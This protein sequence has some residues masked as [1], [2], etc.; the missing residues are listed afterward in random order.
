M[1]SR[2]HVRGYRKYESLTFT[3]HSKFNIL[4]GDNEAGKSTLLEA[5]TLALTGRINGRPAAEEISPFWFN[6]DIVRQFFESR[7]NGQSAALPEILIE[8]T[9]EDRD[10]F[11]KLI[12][13]NNTYSPAKALSGVTFRVRPDSDYGEELEQYL[14]DGATRVLPVE[15]YR[16][17]WTSFQGSVLTQ[18]PKALSVAVIDSR[19]VRSGSGVD[20]HLRQ[21]LNDHLAPEDR[22]AVSVAFRRVK[23]QMTDGHL[24]AVNAK[25]QELEG[26]LHNR[27]LSLAMDQSAKSSWD[28]SV[29]PHVNDIPFGMS[30]LGQQ[31]TTKIALA[32]Q[33]AAGGAGVVM[34]EEPEN[35]LS[36]TSLNALLSQIGRLSAT[37]Q[38]LFVATHSSFVL[39]KLGLDH[40]Q[41]VAGGDVNRFS[42]LDAD[43]ARYFQKLPGFDT[44]RAVV[45][46][47]LVMV[48]GPSDELLFERFYRD[49]Y[50]C[51]PI[52]E[53]IDVFSMRGLSLRRF[54]S[55]ARLLDKP[56]AILS[57]NDGR[58]VDE[59]RS[60]LSSHID[61]K[62][63]VFFSAPA[64]GPTLE[65]QLIAANVERTLRVAAKVPDTA[66]TLKWMTNNKTEAA[67]HIAESTTPVQAPQYFVTAMEF[68]RAR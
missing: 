1:I 2:L 25:L 31:A 29:V 33:Q 67:L 27:H 28:T 47:K 42:D 23:E 41:L 12:G 58:D 35:H 54:L 45:A 17:E 37:S 52:E 22:A 44:L 11:A 39:N 20:F 13:A 8:V 26:G 40:L 61:D 62:R 48:E 21:I 3:P 38:Q 53:G 16:T 43:T 65:P 18:R 30:G 64:G 15:Y 55:L 34:V 14:A 59:A 60:E 46:R 32:M 56:C 4:V 49:R 7:A 5:M 68:I 51:R 66:D 19:T 63:D 50:Q 36:H 57:D 24:A 9:L 6:Q 10:D